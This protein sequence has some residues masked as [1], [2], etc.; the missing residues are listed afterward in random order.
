MKKI[1]MIAIMALASIFIA[2]CNE[3]LPTAERITSIATVAGRTAGYAVELAKT[4]AEVKQVILN[5]VD[6]AS[7]TV[8][9]TNQTFTAAWTPIIDTELNKTKFSDVDKAFAKTACLAACAGIDYVFEK[10]PKA[11][12]TKELMSAAIAGLT[13]GYKSSATLSVGLAP[14]ID[15]DVLA[16]IKTR[17]TTK[18]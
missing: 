4:K 12:E 6:I 9:A 2:G 3:D 14:E 17:I 11:K 13:R 10:C 18:K 5:V 8:P 1:I 15:N 7:K 16:Y